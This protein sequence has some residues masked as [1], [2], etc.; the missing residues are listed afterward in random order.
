MATAAS[1]T[2]FPLPA[3]LPPRLSALRLCSPAGSRCEPLSP[4]PLPRRPR[5]PQPASSSWTAPRPKRSTAST[6]FTSRRSC[7]SSRRSSP[8]ITSTRCQR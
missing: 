1:A 5:R 7:P 6:P 3:T 2:R 8:T 4:S